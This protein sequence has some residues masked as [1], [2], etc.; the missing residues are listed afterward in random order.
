MACDEDLA[1]AV[2]ALLPEAGVY[3]I[4]PANRVWIERKLSL[5]RCEAA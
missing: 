4:D 2:N 3:G 5:V 1:L